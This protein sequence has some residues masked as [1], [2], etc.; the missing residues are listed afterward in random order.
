MPR[1]PLFWF[2]NEPA[3]LLEPQFKWTAVGFDR[4]FD[5]PELIAR[6]LWPPIKS[7][8]PALAGGS[9]PEGL[10]DSSRWSERSGDHRITNTNDFPRWNGGRKR[11]HPSRVR[12]NTRFVPV[13]CATLRPPATIWQPFRL[14]MFSP[15]FHTASFGGEANWATRP[16]TQAVLTRGGIP[17]H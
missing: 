8:P 17:E 5:H 10:S 2:R 13:V 11:G 3:I 15:R 9:Q 16:L 6:Q 4:C 12:A 7:E 1:W 14:K